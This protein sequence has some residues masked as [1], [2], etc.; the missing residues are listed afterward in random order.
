MKEYSTTSTGGNLLCTFQRVVHRVIVLDCIDNS[1]T[2]Q[3]L[4]QAFER[5]F[6]QPP[7]DFHDSSL[8][9]SEH[10]TFDRVGGLQ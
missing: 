7:R 2:C 8:V 10:G 6:G 4:E 5:F 1:V 3:R 9:T